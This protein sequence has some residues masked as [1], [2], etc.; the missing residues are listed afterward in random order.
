MKWLV[1]AGFLALCL[2]AG[3]VGSLLTNQSVKSWYLTLQKPAGTPPDWVFPVVWTTLY[4]VMAVAA[5][6]VWVEA[7]WYSAKQPLILFLAQLAMNVAWS[8]I[9]FNSRQPGF[10][11]GW[12]VLLWLA[13]LTTMIVFYAIKPLAGILL[14]PYIA[15]VTYASFLNFGIWRMNRT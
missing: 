11:F 8:A 7:G 14:V 3:Y 10:A 9:F 5:W 6:L 15:W 1:L 12:I 4:I 2:F 13:I